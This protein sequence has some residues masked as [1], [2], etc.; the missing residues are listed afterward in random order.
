[1]KFTKLV[2]ANKE[3]FIE[4]L[5]DYT[6]NKMYDCGTLLIKL[7]QDLNNKIDNAK[8]VFNY[9]IEIEEALDIEFEKLA[10]LLNDKSAK[11]KDILEKLK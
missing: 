3:N 8:D 1:M 2:K 10:K 5:Q 9:R 6:D 7:Q 4:Q 11:I